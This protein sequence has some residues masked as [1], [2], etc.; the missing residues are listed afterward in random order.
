MGQ[1]YTDLFESIFSFSSLNRSFYS[2][3]K[4]KWDRTSVAKFCIDLEKNILEI[5]D[6]IYDNTYEFGPYRS[7]TIF[8]PKKRKIESASFRD[9]VVHHSI[10]KTL[11]VVFEPKFFFH[12]YACRSG[13]G[14][15]AA[16]LTLKKWVS[17]YPT[18]WFLKCD[19][20]KYFESID[21]E[22]LFKILSESI[23]DE[24]LLSCIKKLI[25]TAPGNKGIPIGNLTSQLF[26]NVYLN[27]LDQY[28]KRVLRKKYYVR[29]MDDFIILVSNHE[30]AREV[31]NLVR[32]FVSNK[33]K[34]ELSPQK[35]LVGRVSE[36][37][38]FVGYMVFPSQIR[39][40]SGRLRSYRQK[41]KK[42]YIESLIGKTNSHNKSWK[43]SLEAFS[44]HASYCD[45]FIDMYKGLICD[46]D[47]L[48]I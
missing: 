36:G 44:G 24:R 31:L 18:M 33:L 30:E 1:V 26:A 48:R 13:R 10:F 4:G 12:S 34:L 15:H 37:V 47:K 14:S 39:L 43:D 11:E 19:I 35:V 28:V 27:E 38:C 20:K 2:A 29:Y 23:N 6:Q 40:R 46:L 25:F 22:I 8:E 5:I 9:R 41:L 32:E 16:M 45:D 7:F 3:A 17:I 42:R 21:R